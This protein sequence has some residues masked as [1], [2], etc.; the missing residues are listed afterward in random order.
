[1]VVTVPI[2]PLFVM[3]ATTTVLLV[4]ISKGFMMSIK[5]SSVVRTM[6]VEP[7]VVFATLLL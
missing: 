4:V 2:S 7:T 5:A 6:G 3:P 1:M